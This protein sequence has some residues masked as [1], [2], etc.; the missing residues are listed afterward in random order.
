ML[1]RVISTMLLKSLKARKINSINCISNNKRE[2]STN[3]GSSL[4]I[5][6][7][8]KFATNYI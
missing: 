8:Y 6:I 2:T 1:F 4:S 3:I 7:S 5:D